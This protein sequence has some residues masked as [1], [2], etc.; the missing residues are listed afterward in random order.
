[1]PNYIVFVSKDHYNPLGIVRT[2]GE[3]GINP[4]VV[5]VKSYPKL[6][7]LS[8]YVKVKHLVNDP[9]E[10][11]QLILSKYA[12]SK[13]EKSFIL[14]GD[15]VTVATLD[16]HYDQL[17]DSFYFYNAGET[18]RIRTV[19]NKDYMCKFAEKHGFCV[20]KT[21]KVRT[22]E[23]P[24]DI[25]YPVITKAI[26]SFGE[27]WKSIV[28]IC[29]NDEELKQ[30]FAGIQKS[31]YVL[32]QQYLEKDDE[33][34]YDGFSINQGRDVFFTVQNNEVYHIAGQYAPYW[35]NKNVDDQ[36]FKKKATAML[37]EIGFEGIFEFEFLVAKDGKHYFLEVN[38]RNTVNGW[39]STVAGMP[40]AT[41]WCE[42]MACG[43]IAESYYK[44]IP[45]GFVTMAEC[46]DYDA[47]VKNGLISHK[48]WMKQYKKVDA[49]LYKGRND[50]IP[51]LSFMWYKVTKMNKKK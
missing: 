29:N 12:T 2:L 40:L 3:A 20:A 15:D 41:L 8:K 13:T 39:T 5:V 14:T 4:I 6:V 30:A 47:R 7:S 27:E 48:E 1:M 43:K 51:F 34:S 24:V 16:A 42:S 11:I 19:L 33:Q 23:I 18:G 38:L 26:H 50:F 46:F 28:R 44:K 49:K 35:K 22:G 9:E 36:D 45:E 21:W 31:E 25:Q 32:L 17:K 10:G 37:S